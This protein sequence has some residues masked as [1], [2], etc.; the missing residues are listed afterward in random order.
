MEML[1]RELFAQPTFAVLVL[2]VVAITVGFAFVLEASL[3][4]VVGM[5]VVGLAT[6]I[7]E[8]VLSIQSERRGKSAASKGKQR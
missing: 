7:S 8:Y 4:V 5:L 2:I 6:A 3:E 1:V